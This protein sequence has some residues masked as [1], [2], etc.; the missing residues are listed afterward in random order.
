MMQTTHFGNRNNGAHRRPLDGPGVR[1]ILLQG[2]VSSSAMI[3][4]EVA[5]QD[6][7]EMPLAEH[8]DMV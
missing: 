6:L 4:G 5:G 1:R 8:E 3:K 2:E 7:A